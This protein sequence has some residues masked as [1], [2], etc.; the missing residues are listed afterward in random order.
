M[1]VSEGDR[2]HV[3]ERRMFETDVRRHFFGAVEV[4]DGLTVRLTGYLFVFDSGTSRYI[5]TD[6]VRTRIVSLASSGLVINV[7]PP[8]TVIE[9]VV[10]VER[11]GRL[12][13]TDGG[14]FNLVINEFGSS[15]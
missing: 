8:E 7:A 1:V 6:E 9:D 2:L 11:G 15:R 12:T 5:R 14:K 10:Y 13:V 3:I 4:A